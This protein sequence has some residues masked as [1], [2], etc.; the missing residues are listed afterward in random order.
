MNQP[1]PPP[2]Q[3]HA[4]LKEMT[5]FIEPSQEAYIRERNAHPINGATGLPLYVPWDKLVKI[6]DCQHG[7]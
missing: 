1:T 6:L 2:C 4:L 5:A 7:Q 3:C